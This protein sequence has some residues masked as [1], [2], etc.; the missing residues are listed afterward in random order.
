CALP[1]CLVT[2]GL[3]RLRNAMAQMVPQQLTADTAQRFVHRRNLRQHIGAVTILF[4]HFL[5][6]AHLALDPLEPCQVFRLEFGFHFHRLTDRRRAGASAVV[7]RFVTYRF[8]HS[9]GSHDRWVTQR[10]NSAESAGA[11]GCWPPHWSN[12]AP[13]PGWRGSG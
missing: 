10:V 5:N 12:S 13:S 6:P 1:I 4:D 8:L 9:H 2:T 11:A 7:T 3:D